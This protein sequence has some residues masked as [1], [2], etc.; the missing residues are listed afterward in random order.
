MVIAEEKLAAC[1]QNRTHLGPCPATVATV[2]GS[3]FGAGE[4]RACHWESPSVPAF[5]DAFDP[6][7]ESWC[8][9]SGCDS[10]GRHRCSLPPPLQTQRRTQ[11]FPRGGSRV[12]P[13]GQAA[14]HQGRGYPGDTRWCVVFAGE[15]RANGQLVVASAVPVRTLRSSVR[16]WRNAV[17]T[18][19]PGAGAPPPIGHDR[20]VRIMTPT[21]VLGTIPAPVLFILS[22]ISMYLGAAVAVGLF[23]VATPAGVA[24][25]RCLGA[26]LV[27]LLWRRPGR[28][29]WR[30]RQLVLA[31]AFGVVTAAMNI[32]F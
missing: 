23:D 16:A 15:R 29:A 10:T 11:M 21:Q 31:G 30:G 19:H 2:C 6:A 18:T 5:G 8:L 22:G 12:R 20:G 28:E 3:Q 27:L 14:V 9:G 17:D 26:A 4:R 13:L 24:W 25:L 7:G 32:V 1:G